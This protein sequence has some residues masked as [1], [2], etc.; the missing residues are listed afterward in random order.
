MADFKPGD[1]VTIS[2]REVTPEDSKSGLYF[3][4]FGGLVGKVDRVYDDGSVCIDVDIDSLSDDARK[5]HEAMENAERKRWLDGLSGEAR[6]RLTD[7]QKQL[8]ISY[9]ILVSN[10]DLKPYNGGDKPKGKPAL[11]ASDSESAP[12]Q[13]NSGPATEPDPTPLE[14][15]LAE[16]PHRLTEAELEAREEEFF[17]S[18]KEKQGN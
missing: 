2:T 14:S 15:D 18:M 4:Y 12:A 11:K 8:K 10:K 16:T 13:S 1:G 5:R 17:K 9:K 7:E 3:E 6:N